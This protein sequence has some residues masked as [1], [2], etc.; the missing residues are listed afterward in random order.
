MITCDLQ[1]YSSFEEKSDF[2]GISVNM[3]G[4][5]TCYHSNMKGSKEGVP[6]Q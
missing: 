4:A 5:S 3:E 2:E 6:L 1:N